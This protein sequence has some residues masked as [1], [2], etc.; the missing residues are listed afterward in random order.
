MALETPAY[1][2]SA[3]S[4]SAALFRQTAQAGLI[5]S[6]VVGNGSLAVSA[7]GTPNMSVN[8]AAGIVW[9]PGTLGATAGMP[10][11]LG[12]QTTYGLPSTFTAQGS[13]CA[14]NDGTVNLPIAAADPTNPRIDLICA[15]VQ[16]A[17]YAGSNNQA[18]LQ[19]V[20]G[21]PAPS[22]SV[23]SAP[24]STEVLAQVAVAAG[25]TSITSGNITD[26]RSFVPMPIKYAYSGFTVNGGTY[27]PA[28]PVQ[29][30]TFRVNSTTDSNA[31]A[32][33]NLPSTTTN[34]LTAF[35]VHE[36]TSTP[37]TAYIFKVRYDQC[38][39]TKAVWQMISAS[40]GSAAAN[41]AYIAEFRVEFQ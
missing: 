22:P 3:A 39:A 17:Q 21:T 20:T 23:P 18:I 10:T 13:Y 15:S 38:T 7:N 9:C 12:A 34:L 41:T 40:T 26:V 16:D 36:S 24:A 25:V 29:V 1:V 35:A 6:G 33:V 11:N 30:E 14:Y 19:V 28:L 31:L 27:N 2:I 4:H 32:F 37:T 5:S 8:V